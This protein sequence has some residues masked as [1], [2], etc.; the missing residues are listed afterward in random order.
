MTQQ[1]V[2][3]LASKCLSSLSHRRVM[4]PAESTEAI[5]DLKKI[6]RG[7]VTGQYTLVDTTPPNVPVKEPTGESDD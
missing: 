1:E 2:Q 7:L 3:L 4:L 6:L 5:S